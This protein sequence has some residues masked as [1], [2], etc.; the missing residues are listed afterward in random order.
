MGSFVQGIRAI[1]AIEALEGRT[2]FAGPYLIATAHAA[3]AI[4]DPGRNRLYVPTTTGSVLRYDLNTRTQLSAWNVGGYLAGGDITPDGKYLYIADQ[5]GAGG[6]SL[7]HKITIDNG[8][9]K[10]IPYTLSYDDY[11]NDV[12]VTSDGKAL[13]SHTGQWGAIRIINTSTDVLT[14]DGPF[15]YGGRI[16]R[17]KDRS[18]AFSAELGISSSTGRAYDAK[19]HAWIEKDSA[20][21]YP[22]A[23]NAAG[24]EI[25][26]GTGYLDRKLSLLR[27]QSPYVAP[28]AYDPNISVLYT[29]DDTNHKVIAIDPRTYAT[30]FSFAVG[31]E[32]VAQPGY[33]ITTFG[34]VTDDGHWLTLTGNDGVRVYDLSPFKPAGSGSI[35]GNVFNDVNG[36]RIKDVGESGLAGRTVWADLDDDK[37]LDSGEP[38]GTT[39]AS[40]NYKIA[41]LSA[42]AYIVRQL[43]PAGW[44]QTTPAG[45]YGVHATLLAGQN[46]TSQNFGARQSVTSTGSIS[47]TVFND[48]NGNGVRDAGELGLGLWK[49]FLDKN[50]NGLLDT[51]EASAL[52]DVNGNWSLGNLAA[53]SYAVRI[54]QFAGTATT[55]SPVNVT[56]TAGQKVTAKLFGEKKV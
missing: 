48:G 27:T 25:A 42:G 2:L 43:L 5:T 38:K 51:G 20:G 56:L 3:E 17:S 29:L 10:N 31:A 47:G 1:P 8:A 40:G 23:I 6:Q 39:D 32:I 4:F 37:V 34:G 46:L 11:G 55:T 28:V 35:A 12:V 53:G 13:V 30:K 16:W 24:S 49:V 44:S 36:N 18:L 7:V 45:G 26:V 22:A 41:S 9:V 33:D 21:A 52:S 19:T 50:N 14:A 54:V 15:T